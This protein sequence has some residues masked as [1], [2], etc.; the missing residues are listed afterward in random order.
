M[1]HSFQDNRQ[2]NKFSLYL[3]QK[4][5]GLINSVKGGNNWNTPKRSVPNMISY[6]MH[7]G[8][9]SIPNSF[10]WA[11]LV[12]DFSIALGVTSRKLYSTSIAG[13]TVAIATPNKISCS[14][15]L[16][17]LLVYSFTWCR[18][19]GQTGFTILWRCP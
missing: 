3:P 4:M 5:L 19:L 12:L 18:F 2:I 16:K 13:T 7:W 9:D 10:C 15:P 11:C 17:T 6:H 8:H 14:P 1:L